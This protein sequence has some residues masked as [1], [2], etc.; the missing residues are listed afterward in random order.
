MFDYGPII[1]ELGEQ[2]D[3]IMTQIV[4]INTYGNLS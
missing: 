2:F 3:L 4:L 1:L